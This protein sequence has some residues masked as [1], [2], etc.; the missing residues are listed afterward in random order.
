MTEDG[1]AGQ[2]EHTIAAWRAAAENGDP[3]APVRV[4]ADD[5]EVI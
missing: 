4:L 3:R 2:P 5:V 1:G